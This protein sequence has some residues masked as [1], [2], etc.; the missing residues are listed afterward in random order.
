MAVSVSR[1]TS[2]D[3]P[4]LMGMIRELAE[5]EKMPESVKIDETRLAADLDKN[6]VGGFV[7]R[8]GD[9]PAAMLLFY[10]AYSTWEGQFIHMEDLYVRPASRRKGYGQRLWRELGVL[11]KEMGVLRIQWDVLDWNSNAIAFYEKMPCE[12]LTKKEGWLL[13]RLNANG[14]AA[15]AEVKTKC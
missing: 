2:A 11:A 7:L 6:A 12:N 4:V 13:Y 3:A 8:E 1:A 9:E 14:I 10:F 5:F 15:L